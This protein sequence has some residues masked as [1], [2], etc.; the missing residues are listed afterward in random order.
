MLPYEDEVELCHAQYAV[1]K[2]DALLLCEVAITYCTV[3]VRA[4]ELVLP[5]CAGRL[6]GLG[7]ELRL[8]RAATA[9]PSRCPAYMPP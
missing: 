5:K 3:V 1:P 9:R 7:G 6:D 2:P 4:V 8:R